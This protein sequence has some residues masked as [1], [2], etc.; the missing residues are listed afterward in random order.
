LCNQS[1][2]MRSLIFSTP[3]SLLSILNCYLLLKWLLITRNLSTPA[4]VWLLSQF[5]S[6]VN[7]H[8]GIK[9]TVLKKSL[10]LRL[11][12]NEKYP[13][14]VLLR[15]LL[16]NTNSCQSRLLYS[17]SCTPLNQSRC[18]IRSRSQFLK[19]RSGVRAEKINCK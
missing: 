10:L 17:A 8:E 16:K 5:T 11:L 18:H 14:L 1:K 2:G 15:L 6:S 4:P 9:T 13:L 3:T 19:H 7:N 12:S